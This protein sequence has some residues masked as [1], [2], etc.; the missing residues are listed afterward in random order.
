MVKLTQNQ[1]YGMAAERPTS[2]PP[3]STYLSYDTGE[4]YFYNIAGIGALISDLVGEGGG[5]GVL[6]QN[7]KVTITAPEMKAITAAPKTLVV[8]AGSGIIIRAHGLITKVRHGGVDFDYGGFTDPAVEL[9]SSITGTVHGGLTL[10]TINASANLIVSSILNTS[11]IVL[12][13]NEGLILQ[14]TGADPSNGNGEFDMFLL[15]EEIDTA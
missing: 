10:N 15:Y 9:K 5:G 8:A 14:G 11:E 12:Q 6:K 2:L 1:Y 7:P 4:F 3:G 13:E